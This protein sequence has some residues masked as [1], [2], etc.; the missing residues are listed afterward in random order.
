M[1]HI[2]PTTTTDAQSAGLLLG[3]AGT[4]DVVNALLANQV[5][6]GDQVLTSDPGDLAQLLDVRQVSA[7]VVNI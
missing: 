1:I 2:K 4:S 3:R 5:V 6:P 7:K